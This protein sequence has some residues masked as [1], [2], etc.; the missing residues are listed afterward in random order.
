MEYDQDLI[1]KHLFVVPFSPINL[2]WEIILGAS[3]SIR[4][5]MRARMEWASKPNKRML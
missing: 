2:T 4:L 3:I 5:R 1:F